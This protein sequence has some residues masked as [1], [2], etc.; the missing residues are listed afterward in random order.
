M[1]RQMV[2]VLAGGDVGQEPGPGRP[3]LMMAIGT[4]PTVT[5]SWHFVQAYLKRTCWLTNK[6]P[7]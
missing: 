7:G 6:L 1:Q 2:G 3:L 4:W 5:W